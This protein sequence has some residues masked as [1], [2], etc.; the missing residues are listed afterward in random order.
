MR[1]IAV[2]VGV[3]ETRCPPTG[4]NGGTGQGTDEKAPVRSKGLAAHAPIGV[5]TPA[6]ELPNRALEIDEVAVVLKCCPATVRREANRGRLRGTRIGQ[7]WRFRPED[8]LAYLNGETPASTSER[9][10]WD[11]YVRK[12]VADAPPLRPEQIAA[13]S[14][15]LDWEPENG[16]AA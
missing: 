12:V 10:A 16:G 4:R 6:I 13:L 3:G 7:R 14:A 1:H 15:L 5:L 9:E 8:V 11:A 2:L